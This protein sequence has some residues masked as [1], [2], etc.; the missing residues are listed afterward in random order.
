MNK[1]FFVSPLFWI[2][3][4]VMVGFFK[5]YVDKRLGLLKLEMTEKSVNLV[6]IAIYGLI[7]AILL[8]WFFAFLFIG[9]GFF[10]GNLL[11][12]NAYGML[13]M[14]GVFLLIVFALL[15]L[16][17]SILRGLNSK[18]VSKIFHKD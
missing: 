7:L 8:I 18:L 13:I 11:G 5:D 10:I 4:W 6:S 9:L 12:N 2:K 1:G 16:K 17:N 3:F 14:A 15:M